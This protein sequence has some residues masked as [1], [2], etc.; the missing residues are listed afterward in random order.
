[1]APVIICIVICIVG[2][3]KPYYAKYA[4]AHSISQLCTVMPAERSKDHVPG[5]K[6]LVLLDRLLEAVYPPNMTA[7]DGAV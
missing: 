6:P 3:T 7:R 5:P 1:M 2:S 4:M